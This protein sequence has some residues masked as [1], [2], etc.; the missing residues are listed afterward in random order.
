M[1]TSKLFP[2]FNQLPASLPVF[3][4]NGALML[5]EGR[6]PLNIF[7]PRYIAMI[8]HAM[9]THRM[10][11]MVQR[12]PKDNALYDVG[13]AGRI[14]SFE[15]TA[16]G[17]FHIMLYG[18]SRFY[19]KE[20][21]KNDAPFLQYNVDFSN[22][23]QDLHPLPTVIMDKENFLPLVKI[24]LDSQGLV[25]DWQAVKKSDLTTL[26]VSLSMICPFTNEEKQ[27]LLEAKTIQDVADY[28]QTLMHMNSVQTGSPSTMVN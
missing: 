23:K 8:E 13:C 15:E 16:D 19:L 27:A 9:A 10:I 25:A 7:E 22:F 28:L 1:K 2:T 6:L 14:I 17:R 12:H 20:R 3:P 11:G 5:P 24:Y 18:V 26:I 21:I 4:L